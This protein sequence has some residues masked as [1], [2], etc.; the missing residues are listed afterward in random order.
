MRIVP[1]FP[2]GDLFEFGW[3]V[4]DEK[5]HIPEAFIFKV[6]KQLASVVE[7]LHA[8]FNRDYVEASEPKKYQRPSLPGIIHRDIKPENILLRA[9]KRPSVMAPDLEPYPDMVLADFGL[10][11]FDNEGSDTAGTGMWMPPEM[12]DGFST[13]SDVC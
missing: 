8:G 7:F 10:A 13:K 6:F 11:T 9:T 12:L 4:F 3:H 5:D 1:F 2:L